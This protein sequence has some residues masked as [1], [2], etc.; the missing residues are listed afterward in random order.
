[1]LPWRKIGLS[2]LLIPIS[3]RS[4]GSPSVAINVWFDA[5]DLVS[6]GTNTCQDCTSSS[7]G[8]MAFNRPAGLS[9]IGWFGQTLAACDSYDRPVYCLQE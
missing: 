8:D 3:H 4:D 5:E 2:I 7:S 1:M 9:G 6:F